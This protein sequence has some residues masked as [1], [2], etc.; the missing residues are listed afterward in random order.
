MLPLLTGVR[1]NAGWANANEFS[2]DPYLAKNQA[3]FMQGSDRM[4]DLCRGLGWMSSG[5]M[6]VL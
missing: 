6:R 2:H 5:S 1:R 3:L 4:Q